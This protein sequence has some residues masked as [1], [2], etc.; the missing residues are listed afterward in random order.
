[1]RE[2]HLSE[3]K[4]LIRQRAASRDVHDSSGDEGFAKPD[5]DS[6]EDF[7]AREVAR[8]DS[9]RQH[10]NPLLERYVGGARRVLDFG[11]GT[12]GTTVA[13]A[14]SA[15]GADE[16]VGVDANPAVLD[17][18]RVR[19]RGYDLAPPR[20]RFEH[21]NP[22]KPLPFAD[23]SLDLVVT[24][25]VL[26]FITRAGDRDAVV[27]ELRRVVAPGGFLF[28]ATPRPGV[29]EYHSRHW[30][31]DVR[32]GAGMPWSS[33]PWQVARWGDGWRRIALTDHLASS[34]TQRLPW[35][36]EALAARALGPV[37]P[38]VARW[39]K[40]LWQRPR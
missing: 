36:P 31:G 15:L 20:V 3:F 14:L 22:G 19:A 12:G 8:A 2:P 26:E 7:V 28:V 33:P 34:V 11:C 25:S 39:Q 23:A 29:R 32:R 24:V 17:A 5:G 21:T 38:F 37:L 30:F 10:L 13:M 6:D 4:A 40:A 18:A 35:V 16:V 9:H 1:M 27:A